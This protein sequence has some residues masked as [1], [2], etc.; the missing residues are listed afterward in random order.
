MI[1]LVA[2]DLDDTLYPERQY[3]ASGFR[4]VAQYL[5][6]SLETEKDFFP[7]LE[8]AFESGVRGTTFNHV[9]EAAGVEAGEGF[10]RD[11]LDVYREHNPDIAPYEDVVPTLE[12]LK[13]KY[14][15]GLISDGP[16]LSQRRKWN[17]LGL[18][19]F[20]DKVIFT[21]EQGPEFWKP[22]PWAFLEMASEF[23]L[24]PEECVYV[25]DR[26]GK[27]IEGPAEAGWQKILVQRPGRLHGDAAAAQGE[28]P[29]F[30]SGGIEELP[31]WLGVEKI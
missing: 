15:L 23:R 12:E 1:K 4:A 25:G 11:L 21:D 19:E 16:L 10:I 29:D 26:P 9:L 28:G 20:F 3:V 18:A 24:Q 31:A 22:N 8:E 17:A 13:G 30:V 6:K 27:D 2:F 5:K 14:L 7:P